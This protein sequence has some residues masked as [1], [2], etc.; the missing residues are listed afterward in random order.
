MPYMLRPPRDPKLPCS[1]LL[2]MPSLVGWYG[3]PV[4]NVEDETRLPHK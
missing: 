1:G 2:I 4:I 3:V